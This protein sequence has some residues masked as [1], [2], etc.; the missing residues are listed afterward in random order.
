MSV[1]YTRLQ[2]EQIYK[3]SLSDLIPPECLKESSI[4]SYLFKPIQES[5]KKEVERSK[6]FIKDLRANVL[7]TYQK[8]CKASDDEYQNGVL[9]NI[10][11]ANTQ[12]VNIDSAAQSY[13]Y[14]GVGR[15]TEQSIHQF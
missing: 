9:K 5:V 12:L 3:A 13:N 8:V 4:T 1:F 2:I 10:D 11:I 7:D 14:W 6:Q 15:Q